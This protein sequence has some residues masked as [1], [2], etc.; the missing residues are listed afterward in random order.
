MGSEFSQIPA[1]VAFAAFAATA[2]QR[3]YSEAEAHVAWR[4]AGGDHMRALRVLEERRREREHGGALVRQIN[5]L[6]SEQRPWN[7]FFARFLWPEHLYARTQTNLLYAFQ[8]KRPA[9]TLVGSLSHALTLIHANCRYYRAN[10]VI[11]VAGVWL[12]GALAMPTLLVCTALCGMALATASNW[13][14]AQP[15]P[16]LDQPLSFEQRLTAATLASAAIISWV[17]CLSQACRVLL[18]AFGLVLGHATFRARSL[19]ARWA[20]FVHEAKQD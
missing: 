14:D 10:Y 4:A 12:V 1:Q 17:N 11:I 9:Q 15:I 3:G 2:I 19:S 7:E 8:P 16:L 6:L 18:L 5:E 13:G 20:E